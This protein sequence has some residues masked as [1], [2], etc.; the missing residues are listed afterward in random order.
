ML[1]LTGV[2][3]QSAI[4]DG[5]EMMNYLPLP[6]TPYPMLKKDF[7]KA[8]HLAAVDRIDLAAADSVMIRC[9]Y[10]EDGLLAAAYLYK[11]YEAERARE[12]EEDDDEEGVVVFAVDDDDEDFEEEQTAESVIYR[13]GKTAALPVVSSREFYIVFDQSRPQMGFGQMNMMMNASSQSKEPYW[14]RGKYPLIVVEQYNYPSIHAEAIRHFARNRRFLIYILAGPDDA[15]GVA[16]GYAEKSVLFE[17]N[18]EVCRIAKPDFP[19]YER[20]LEQTAR[21]RGMNISRSVNK[22]QLIKELMEYRGPLFRSNFDVER[23]VAQALRKKK[24]GRSSLTASDFRNVF[25]AKSLH[26]R[27]VSGVGQSALA[28]LDGMVGMEPVKAQLKRLVTTLKYQHSRKV[29]GYPVAD[30]HLG[31]VFMGNPGTAKTTVARILGRAL[32]EEGILSNALFREVSRKDLVGQYVGWTA[33]AVARL[34]E[35]TDGGTIFI[36]EAYS[37]WD[38]EKRDGFSD[39]AVSELIRQ[40]ENHP[41]TLVIFAG[42][43]DKMREFIRNANPGLRS[44]LTRLIEFGDYGDRELWDIFRWFLQKEDY[45]LE[46]AEA[47]ERAVRGFLDRL[48]DVPRETLGNGRLMRKL[49]Q[50]A[51]QHMAERSDHDFRTIRTRDIE[52]AAEELAFSEQLLY[53][54]NRNGRRIGF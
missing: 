17:T 1:H 50:T 9:A 14:T 16:G 38:G 34:F 29:L 3:T 40:M 51:V 21:A 53:A 12:D 36:D 37:L 45:R 18:M 54:E 13:G 4:L 22:T 52:L 23:L 6:E 20:V 27:S 11:K 31:V 19:Y 8:P 49:F 7:R 44:R 47:A 26:H 24:K 41:N 33:P 42:Y 2:E 35:E 48:K 46:N 5:G 28:E 32:C 10:Q 39:E 15:P 30:P 25:A 43:R